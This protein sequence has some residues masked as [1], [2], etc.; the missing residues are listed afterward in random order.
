M[1]NV[2]INNIYLL[3][4]NIKNIINSGVIRRIGNNSPYVYVKSFSV[5]SEYNIRPKTDAKVRLI[6]KNTFH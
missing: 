2:I 3:L 5:I 4:K 1:M 6:A